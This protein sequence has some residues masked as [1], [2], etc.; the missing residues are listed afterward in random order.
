ML[1]IWFSLTL[2]NVEDPQQERGVAIGHGTVRYRWHRFGPMFAS[3][4]RKRRIY[5]MKSSLWRWHLDEIFVKIKGERLYLWRAVD[6]R[7]KLLEGFVSEPRD[8][9][10]ALKRLKK[11]LPWCGRPVAKVT[12][13]LRSTTLP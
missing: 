13:L 11:T 4:I 10:A 3:E 8:E 6:H 9:K 7:S 1:Y 5:G 2:R 12:D